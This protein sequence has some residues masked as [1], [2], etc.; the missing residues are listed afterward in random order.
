MR[1]L[2]LL[3]L[4]LVPGLAEAQAP[5]LRAV[6]VAGD[7]SLEVWDRGIEAIAAG[8][9]AGGALV[10]GQVV[11]F[12]ARKDRLKAGVRR[13]RIEPVLAAIRA[14]KPAPGEGCLVYLTMHGIHHEGL[15][16]AVSDRA[17]TPAA[18]D[19]ALTAGCGDAP[20]FV[21]ASGCY[22]GD[23]AAPPMARANR[24]VLT[25]A[26]ADRP[27]FGC[28]AQFEVTVFDGCMAAALERAPE[29]AAMLAARA[30]ECV[31]A[32]EQRLQAQ[33]SNPQVHIGDRV[34]ALVPRYRVPAGG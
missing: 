21:V 27:S 6:L 16:F 33:P 28:G 3:A 4:L 18:L 31:E 32:F 2:L 17:L 20:T 26:E 24:V 13:A 25:A 22:S 1:A 14:L 23:F 29:T 7:A 19:A 5:K 10:P 11:R 8:L 12:S 34:P 30:M 15:Y 9:S